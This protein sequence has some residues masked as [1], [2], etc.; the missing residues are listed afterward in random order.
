MRK[1]KYKNEK[2]RIPLMKTDRDQI[3]LDSRGHFT[4][5]EHIVYHDPDVGS[6]THTHTLNVCAIRRPSEVWKPSESQAKN[7]SVSAF[8][9]CS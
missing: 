7:I 8:C 2:I 9:L 6:H 4:H 1:R 5:C 3:L